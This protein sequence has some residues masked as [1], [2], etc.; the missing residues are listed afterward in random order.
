MALQTAETCS[1]DCER[2]ERLLIKLCRRNKNYFDVL[3]MSELSTK[4]IAE[5][6]RRTPHCWRAI[7]IENPLTKY[8]GKAVGFYT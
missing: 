8:D 3:F 5:P 6:F 2:E 1:P 7:D 4:F